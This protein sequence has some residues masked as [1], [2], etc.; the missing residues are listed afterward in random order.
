MPFVALVVGF[1]AG[2][3]FGVVVLSGDGSVSA[4]VDRGGAERTSSRGRG[5]ARGPA[6]A[7]QRGTRRRVSADDVL[8]ENALR[9]TGGMPAA[10]GDGV[11]SGTITDS[12]GNPVADVDIVAETDLWSLA[13]PPE[14]LR[15]DDDD[16]LE[17]RIRRLVWEHRFR[18]ATRTSAV[19]DENGVYRLEGLAAATYTL[20]PRKDGWRFVAS[21][22]GEWDASPGDTRDFTARPVVGVAVTVVMPDG[23]TPDE[24]YVN[25][26]LMGS[27]NTTS[28]TWS[29]DAEPL[30]LGVGLYMFNAASGEHS[31]FA[32][33]DQDVEVTADGQ[34]LAEL[35]LVARPGVIG[36]IEFSG[37]E[38]PLTVGVAALSLDAGGEVGENMLMS[39]S[40][41]TWVAEPFDFALLDLEPGSYLVGA[42]LRNGT[43][44]GSAVLDV[45]DA[46]LVHSFTVGNVD[47][48]DYVVV[49]P[50]TPDGSPP[51]EVTFVVG[52]AAG[53][54]LSFQGN[55]QIEPEPDGSYRVP[56]AVPGGPENDY[57]GWSR[58]GEVRPGVRYSDV[59]HFVTARST[60]FG[61]KR[62][63]YDP[64][65]DREVELVFS[66][67]A[68]AV[69]TVAGYASSA[70]RG[71]VEAT[72]VPVDRASSG[73]SDSSMS[74]DQRRMT[75]QG[76]ARVGP[77]EP[78]RYVVYLMVM[79]PQSGYRQVAQSE[80][81]LGAG[82]TPVTMSVPELHDLVVVVDGENLDLDLH[83]DPGP[84]EATD[85]LD[86]GVMDGRR[87]TFSMMVAGRYRVRH[88]GEASTGEMIVDVP[89]SG[90]IAFRPVAYDSLRVDQVPD[91][92]KG[93]LRQGD[94]VVAINGE[95]T[96]GGARLRAA[97][98]VAQTGDTAELTVRRGGR[99]LDVEVTST[100]L[101]EGYLV[102]WVR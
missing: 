24:A 23:T 79:T 20:A 100:I 27:G 96:R 70:W 44:L 58:S 43:V 93:V 30:E 88:Y 29:R 15:E 65:A 11:V 31:E 12:L 98:A 67:P 45:S 5:A 99:T 68:W 26:G 76:V 34:G 13:E 74:D 50:R 62:I 63:E 72:L 4:A 90:P 7:E 37:N 19:T 97:M 52:Y 85:F 64:A 87:T 14:G 40:T 83:R 38:R 6:K 35:R 75:P 42:V 22:N 28:Y 73:G 94:I 61:Q 59:T 86:E 57:Q 41:A 9:R 82:E 81:T 3:A 84:G 60:R 66:E 18:Q 25:Y 78:G 53:E 80:V 51:G 69:V 102:Y 54:D 71:R 55:L 101:E 1:T 21:S 91:V 77:V 2:A 39:A 95:E 36:S 92:A 33:S 10:R 49:R 47:V 89:A 56:V 46:T 17:V 8:I 32:V 48:R 16:G